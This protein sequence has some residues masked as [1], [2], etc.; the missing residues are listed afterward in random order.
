V[1]KKYEEDVWGNRAAT[2]GCYVAKRE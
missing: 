1:N 2:I